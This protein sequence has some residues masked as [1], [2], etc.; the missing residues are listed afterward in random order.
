LLI[1]VGVRHHSHVMRSST[2]SLT[3]ARD[4]SI[5][6]LGYRDLT[7]VLLVCRNVVVQLLRLLRKRSSNILALGLLGHEL[8]DCSLKLKDLVLDLAVLSRC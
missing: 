3:R 1:Q 4:R 6:R 5:K 2:S 7:G 8:N